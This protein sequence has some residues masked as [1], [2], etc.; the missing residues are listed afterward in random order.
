MTTG[1]IIFGVAMWLSVLAPL[2]VAL[3][4]QNR[5]LIIIAL[6]LV[7]PT[8]AKE[9]SL[10]IEPNGMTRSGWSFETLTPATI[11]GSGV[12][13][14]NWHAHPGQSAEW[15][16]KNADYLRTGWAKG[17][18]APVIDAG[19][20]EAVDATFSLANASPQDPANNSG[21]WRVLESQVLS[22]VVPG[23]TVHVA[24]GPVFL[25][26]R[27]GVIRISTLG[28]DRVWI[29]THHEKAVLVDRGPNAQGSRYAM[30]GW[31][32]ANVAGAKLE[33]VTVNDIEFDSGRELFCGLL[34]AETEKEL[35]AQK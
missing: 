26:G 30:F 15:C 32:L 20:Q 4:V 29:P 28:I 2:S 22:M 16:A 19:A 11:N 14:D 35:E 13:R 9:P 12:R 34:P 6:L 8:D 3:W 25:P 33:S 17:H 31:R 27:E 24:T 7:A 21:T 1:E 23:S 18:H 5:P 10:R